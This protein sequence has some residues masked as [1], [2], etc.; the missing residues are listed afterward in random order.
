VKNDSNGDAPTVVEQSLINYKVK[1][2]IRGDLEER[3]NLWNFSALYRN[4]E[5]SRYGMSDL[6]P[7]GSNRIGK[8]ETRGKCRLRA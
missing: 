8:V 5:P 4:T 2:L 3:T 6:L 1:V 7:V